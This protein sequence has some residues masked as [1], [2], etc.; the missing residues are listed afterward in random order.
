MKGK[1][2]RLSRLQMGIAR[3]DSFDMVLGLRHQRILQCGQLSIQLIYRI[4]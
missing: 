1:A 4:P 3:H 2:H